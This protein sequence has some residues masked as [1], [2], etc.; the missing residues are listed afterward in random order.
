MAQGRYQLSKLVADVFEISDQLFDNLSHAS[1]SD[2]TDSPAQMSSSSIT[3][4]M[5]YQ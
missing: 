1:G 5:G 2:R 4:G 3:F